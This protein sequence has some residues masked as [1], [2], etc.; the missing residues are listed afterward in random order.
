M[1]SKGQGLEI[2]TLGTS[3]EEVLMSEGIT[4]EQ[5][6][7][8]E[9]E[10]DDF[11]RKNHYDSEC[12]GKS[13]PK[14]VALGKPN[15]KIIK[16]QNN[17]RSVR[18]QNINL[19]RTR[20]TQISQ[21][22]QKLLSEDDSQEK[23]Q[24]LSNIWWALIDKHRCFANLKLLGYPGLELLELELFN[25]LCRDARDYIEKIA[26]ARAKVSPE[27]CRVFNKAVAEYRARSPINDGETPVGFE[28]AKRVLPANHAAPKTRKRDARPLPAPPGPLVVEITRVNQ[29]GDQTIY[30]IE[31]APPKAPK[32]VDSSII[33]PWA[34]IP[35]Q[36]GVQS[37]KPEETQIPPTPTPPS[38]AKIEQQPAAT[39]SPST[40]TSW[41]NRWI[42][43]TINAVG[44]GIEDKDRE[45]IREKLEQA[46]N[47]LSRAVYS[48]VS[49]LECFQNWR[50]KS[51]AVFAFSFVEDDFARERTTFL[52]S[53][54]ILQVA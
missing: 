46:G 12:R 8:A 21:Y 1:K 27:Y 35:G 15:T 10:V 52:A 19:A 33:R 30:Q 45:E 4:P 9:R 29:G 3:P 51:H 2:S 38:E 28:S 47:D 48:H 25:I 6:A 23:Q 31:E 18:V 40:N 17:A 50:Y 49:Y 34:K 5:M 26:T 7:L 36:S 42:A 11:L 37:Q 22:N 16:P 44:S 14:Q 20:H 43:E 32:P 53:S 39:P 13:A 41:V 24:L 54:L